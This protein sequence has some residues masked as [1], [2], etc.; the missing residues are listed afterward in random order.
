MDLVPTLTL[1]R[2]QCENSAWGLNLR[3]V[4]TCLAAAR[5]LGAVFNKRVS[6]IDRRVRLPNHS[7]ETVRSREWGL[8]FGRF[9]DS[10]SACKI[11]L[12]LTHLGSSHI[13]VNR[14]QQ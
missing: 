12:I 4:S 5:Q 11:G 10:D 1:D 9:P 6:A 2:R 7:V 14:Q 8:L 13:Q 3:L